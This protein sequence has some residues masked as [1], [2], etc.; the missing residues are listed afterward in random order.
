MRKDDDGQPVLYVTL[1][2][3]SRH[4]GEVH[5]LWRAGHA[6][7]EGPTDELA[8]HQAGASRA[9]SLARHG[10]SRG[11][12]RPILPVTRGVLVD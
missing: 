7:D 2:P 6:R 12:K 1:C 4:R 5:D 11:A 9:R 10:A 3:A 8:M